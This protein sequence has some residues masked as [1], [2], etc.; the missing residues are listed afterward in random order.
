MNLYNH[1]D[2]DS[3]DCKTTLNGTFLSNKPVK[4][5]H[6]VRTDH[7]Q[8]YFSQILFLR[9]EKNPINL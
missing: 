1:L 6:R 3:A 5:V 2:T 7:M 9:K 4:F 8:E